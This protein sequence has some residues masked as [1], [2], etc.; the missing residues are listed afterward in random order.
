MIQNGTQLYIFVQSVLEKNSKTLYLKSY[1]DCVFI[2][3][4]LKMEI[5][6][7]KKTSLLR[8]MQKRNTFL[9]HRTKSYPLRA[10]VV[11]NTILNLDRF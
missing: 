2:N 5:I 10:A 11:A 3:V 1:I 8:S 6:L 4:P 7:L 9:N